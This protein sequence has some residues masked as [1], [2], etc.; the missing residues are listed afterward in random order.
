MYILN[1]PPHLPTA[2]LHIKT[3]FIRSTKKQFK[4][5]LNNNEVESKS[6]KIVSAITAYLDIVMDS[7]IQKNPAAK[8][9][10]YG[11]RPDILAEI[12]EQSG[13]DAETG[14]EACQDGNEIA[15]GY[16]KSSLERHKKERTEEV[17]KEEIK[18]LVAELPNA[19]MAGELSKVLAKYE[20]SSDDHSSASGHSQ[21]PS[22]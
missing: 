3:S 20:E 11:K 1:S 19:K 8:A 2:T 12:S 13:L 18:A 16:I 22:R 17:M 6:K 14:V 10:A 5:M 21:P 4:N 15:Q 7:E 9:E